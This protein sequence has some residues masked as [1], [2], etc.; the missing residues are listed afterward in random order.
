[1]GE[2]VRHFDGLLAPIGC[3]PLKPLITNPARRNPNR[4]SA[5]VSLNVRQLNIAQVMDKVYFATVALDSAV[6]REEAAFAAGFH[7]R[8]RNLILSLSMNT[9]LHRTGH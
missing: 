8:R 3:V 4:C 2:V 6:L 5:Q 9:S 7:W 1:M